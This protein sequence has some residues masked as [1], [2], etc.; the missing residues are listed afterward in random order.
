ML[1]GSCA[2]VPCRPGAPAD[3]YATITSRLAG[4]DVRVAVDTSG[5]SL[6]AVDRGDREADA[7]QAQRRGTGDHRRW[8]RR[9]VRSRSRGSRRGRPAAGRRRDRDRVAHPWRRRKRRGDRDVESLFAPPLPVEPRSTVGAGDS[10][11]TGWVLADLQRPRLGHLPRVG[12]CLGR[13]RRVPAGLDASHARR[14]SPRTQSWCNAS[15]EPRPEITP[16][17]A[18]PPSRPPTHPRSTAGASP[19]HPP[20]TATTHPRTPTAPTTAAPDHPPSTCPPTR[21]ATWNR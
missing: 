6:Q 5:A 7:H 12:H 3:L 11:L 16:S 13:G 17:H 19:T 14:W 20:G 15:P 2:P 18:T 21:S 1:G 8:R 9:P 4:H 10:A